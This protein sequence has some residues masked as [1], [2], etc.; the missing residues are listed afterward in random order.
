M[1]N[2]KNCKHWK[3][4]EHYEHGSCPFDMGQRFRESYDWCVTDFKPKKEVRAYQILLKI[5]SILNNSTMK[6]EDKFKPIYALLEVFYSE[7]PRR[8]KNV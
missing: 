4:A 3:K 5:E 6:D 1:N 2:C 7:F 8:Y